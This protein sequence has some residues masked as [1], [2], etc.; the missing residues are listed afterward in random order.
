MQQALVRFLRCG[1][2]T[3]ARQNHQILFESGFRTPKSANSASNFSKTVF[4]IRA[5]LVISAAQQPSHAPAAS[6][7]E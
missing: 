4:A 7:G 5:L 6:A 2:N 3:S 1:K